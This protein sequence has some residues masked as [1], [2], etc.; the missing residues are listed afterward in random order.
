MAFFDKINDFAKNTSEKANNAIETSKL[1]SKITAEDRNISAITLKI[2]EYYLAKIDAGET[3]DADVMNMYAG[4]TAAR[5]NIATIRSEIEVM[6]T[7]KPE[8]APAP[9]YT[10]PNAAPAYAPAPTYAEQPAA[11]TYAAPEAPAAPA[12]ASAFKFC[13]SCGAKLDPD[14]RFC[15]ECGS[16]Q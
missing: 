11:P 1:N 2:G 14:A 6:N 15:P 5:S 9:A 3:L 10:D 12:A 4:I 7:P 13:C 16:A 8:P